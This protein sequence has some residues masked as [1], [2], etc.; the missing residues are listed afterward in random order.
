MA[1]NTLIFKARTSQQEHQQEQQQVILI[2]AYRR[3][4]E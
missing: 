4:Q 3:V 2:I 1:I